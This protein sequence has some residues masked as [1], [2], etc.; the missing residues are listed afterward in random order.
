[1]YKA[2]SLLIIVAERMSNPKKEVR[3]ENR[4]EQMFLHQVSTN[5]HVVKQ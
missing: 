2:F 5:R 3:T 1:M 4:Q